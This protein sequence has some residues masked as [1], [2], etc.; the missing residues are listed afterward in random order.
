MRKCGCG[1]GGFT[2]TELLVASTIGL[3]ATAAVIST[4]VWCV[5]QSV[6]AAKVAWSQNEATQTA[7]KLTDYVRNAKTIE[8]VDD[9]KGTW[10]KLRLTDNSIVSLVYTNL[11]AQPRDGRMLLIRTNNTQTLVTHGLTGLMDS[12]GGALKV[13]SRTPR[14]NALRIAYRLADPTSAGSGAVND[15]DYA[16][17]S[18]FVVCLRNAAVP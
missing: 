1:D 7:F 9:N 12:Q 11:T 10:V 2:L 4:F 15:G 18:H 14:V 6:L 17:C 3:L 16:V 13:F 8:S 5:T